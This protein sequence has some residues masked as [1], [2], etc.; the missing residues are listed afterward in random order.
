MT[1]LSWMTLNGVDRFEE[2]TVFTTRDKWF[3]LG[4]IMWQLDD[5]SPRGRSPGAYSIKYFDVI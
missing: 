1:F 2:I 3:F 4:G 5:A